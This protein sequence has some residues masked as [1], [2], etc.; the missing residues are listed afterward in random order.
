MDFI[1]FVECMICFELC[2]GN[3][4]VY[5]DCQFVGQVMYRKCIVDGV[6]NLM[7]EFFGMNMMFFVLVIS[8]FF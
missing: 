4:I 8:V 5:S 7:L 3:E 2:F 6:L 1:V